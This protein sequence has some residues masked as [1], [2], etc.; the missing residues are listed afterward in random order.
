MC[1]FYPYV[2]APLS[3]VVLP[4]L[5]FTHVDVTELQQQLY[6]AAAHVLDRCERIS[7]RRR[8]FFSAMRWRVTKLDEPPV[9]QTW[10]RCCTVCQGCRM[11]AAQAAACGV[12]AAL[13][14]TIGVAVCVAADVAA[15]IRI[16]VKSS[17]H[18]FGCAPWLAAS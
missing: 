6:F 13:L 17:G 16:V 9:N 14:P 15:G 11:Q 10:T 12:G 1:N 3:L 5:F 18:W 4:M 7:G 8:L 2:L